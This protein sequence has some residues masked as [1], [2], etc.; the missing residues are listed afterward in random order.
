MTSRSKFAFRID[1]LSR[2]EVP[3]RDLAA[4]LTDLV[5][6][7]GHY[8]AVRFLGV[9]DG[10]LELRYEVDD[11]AVGDVDERVKEAQTSIGDPTARRA[12]RNLDKRLKGHRSSAEIV[13]HLGAERR[14]TVLEIPGALDTESPIPAV[15]S[16]GRVDGIPTGI[17]GKQIDPDWMLVRLHDAGASLRCEARPPVAIK[18]GQYLLK[19]P[20]RATGKGRWVRDENDGWSLDRFQIETFEELDDRSLAEI[21]PELRKVYEDTDWANMEDPI[22]SLARLRDSR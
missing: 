5:H 17:G 4:Y 3:M 12:Y 15:W 10:S 8:E 16:E 22:D 21:V 18:I 13:G 20:I 7:L 6:L 14:R 2:D 9:R 19:K 11:G 1:S